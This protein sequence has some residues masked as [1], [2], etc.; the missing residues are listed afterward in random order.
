MNL[1][2]KWKNRE[3]KK[4]LREENIRLKEENKILSSIPKPAVCTVDRNVQKICARISY[5]GMELRLPSETIKHELKRKLMENIEPFIEYNFDKNGYGEENYTAI[6]YAATG[7]RKY[8][9]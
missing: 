8:G 5:S 6:L 7:D 9:R 3:T 1:I 4:K 2:E